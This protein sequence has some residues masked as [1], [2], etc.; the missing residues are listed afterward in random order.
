MA[1]RKTADSGHQIASN[2]PSESRARENRRRLRPKQHYFTEGPTCRRVASH[3]HCVRHLGRHSGLDDEQDIRFA[4]AVACVAQ[5]AKEVSPE[6]P[7]WAVASDA[8]NRCWINFANTTQTEPGRAGTERS[9]AP[10]RA[11]PCRMYVPH[12]TAPHGKTPAARIHLGS[13]ARGSCFVLG[14]CR[15]CAAGDARRKVEMQQARHI[16]FM[17]SI[18]QRRPLMREQVESTARKVDQPARTGAPERESGC[19]RFE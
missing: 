3:G 18:A 1:T 4:S 12:D 11:A 14:S 13:A 16:S 2:E 10:P 8:T 6:F 9:G 19:P 17:H 5:G 7:I 15:R